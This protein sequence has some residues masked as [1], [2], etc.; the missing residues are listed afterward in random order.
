MQMYANV[1]KVAWGWEK[2]QVERG[3]G[4]TFEELGPG[5]LEIPAGCRAQADQ[6]QMC[7]QGSGTAA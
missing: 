3:Q 7:I 2:K 6:T 5:A 1:S 4:I